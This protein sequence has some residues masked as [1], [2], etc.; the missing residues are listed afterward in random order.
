MGLSFPSLGTLGEGTVHPHT[1]CGPPT[2]NA[3]LSPPPSA[4]QIQSEVTMVTQTVQ[5]D[6]IFKVCSMFQTL[7]PGGGEGRGHQSHP[8]VASIVWGP[9]SSAEKVRLVRDGTREEL[10]MT[11]GALKRS[12]DRKVPTC[13]VPPDCFRALSGPPGKSHPRVF[14]QGPESKGGAGPGVIPIWV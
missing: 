12:L 1:G 5:C 2:V 6:Q 4:K 3:V 9:G 13:P 11:L 14:P 8:S 7:H 10:E